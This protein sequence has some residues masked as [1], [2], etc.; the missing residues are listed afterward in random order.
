MGSAPKRK[1][2]PVEDDEPGEENALF[3]VGKQDEDEEIS[4]GDDG[5]S[6]SLWDSDNALGDVGDEDEEGSDKALEEEGD[7]DG[8][9]SDSAPEEGDDH[10]ED[11]EKDTSGGRRLKLNH[12]GAEMEELE[13][14]YENLRHQEQTI[15]SGLK[16]QKDKDF[17]KGQAIK[18]QKALWNRN[19]EFRFLLQKAFSNS[20]KLPQEPLRSQFCHRDETI[21][22]AYSELILS[23]EQT[24]NSML[25]LQEA[26][27]EKN[28]S[29]SLENDGISKGIVSFRNSSIDRWQ[30]K[31]Q[32]TSGAAAFKSKL[33]A[34]NK[35]ISDQ[36]AAHM[37]D[38][39]RMIDRMT[40][41]RSSVGVLGEGAEGP[42]TVGIEGGNVDGDPELID[43]SE[44]YQQLLKEFFETFDLSSEPSLHAFK[45]FQ[46]K[47]RKTVDRRA[48]KNRK[49]RY[50]VH[51]KIVN[52]M[53]P[54]PMVLP[55]T[56]PKLFE[57][58]FGLRKKQSA[59]S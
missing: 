45:K 12:G 23:S 13:K 17:V 38:P 51:D 43:D 57:N 54:R 20:N 18:N 53:A 56:A 31:T 47:K 14:E 28:G 16:R 37:R 48:S 29:I 26:L 39:S 41:K 52:F 27:V 46:T 11:S 59:S 9:E 3:N 8:K 5:E 7:D 21:D 6:D 10:Q 30:K 32:L 19:L 15:L 50:N 24:L 4:S 55:P 49:I 2:R 40:L 58:L 33:H 25:E 42:T 44:F 36:V 34:F 1:R 22:K 35:N